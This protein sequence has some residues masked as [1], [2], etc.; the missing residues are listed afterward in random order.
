MVLCGIAL[1]ILYTVTISKEKKEEFNEWKKKL[2]L[3]YGGTTLV[4]QTGIYEDKDNSILVFDCQKIIIMNG[5]TY[6]YNEILDFDINNQMSYKTSTS[7]G[8]MLGRAVV[9]GVL[10]GGVGAFVGGATARKKTKTTIEKYK[11]NIYIRRMN[12]PLV[13]ITTEYVSVVN[14][15]SAVLKNIIDGNNKMS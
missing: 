14:T 1:L 12:S 7:T 5:I 13:T 2:E 9:G 10:T 6:T 4:I 15:I 3:K 11:V 8:S